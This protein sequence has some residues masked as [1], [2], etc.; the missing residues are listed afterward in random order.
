M[1]E[2]I[3][4]LRKSEDRRGSKPVECRGPVKSGSRTG[5]GLGVGERGMRLRSNRSPNDTE[6]MTCLRAQ[7]QRT[8]GRPENDST[9]PINICRHSEDSR[10][11]ALC[12]KKGLLR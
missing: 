2:A 8:A 3:H 1:V 10:C 4:R 7:M 11:G 12:Q 6:V 9:Q 5:G